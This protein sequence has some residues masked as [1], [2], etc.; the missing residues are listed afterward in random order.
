[1]IED[2]KVLEDLVN[3]S[4]NCLGS[5]DVEDPEK[6]PSEDVED[7]LNR[8]TNS[9]ASSASSEDRSLLLGMPTQ[10]FSK[11]CAG[12]AEDKQQVCI[13]LNLWFRRGGCRRAAASHL[14]N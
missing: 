3:D 14:L 2:P 4:Q 13:S 7:V 12:T 10:A 8:S 6:Q 5:V 11:H 1:M 9:V